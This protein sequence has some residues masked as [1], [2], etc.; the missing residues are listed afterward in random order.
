MKKFK[1]WSIVLLTGGMFNFSNLANVSPEVNAQDLVA[2][3]TPHTSAS[4]PKKELSGSKQKSASTYELMVLDIMEEN[5]YNLADIEFDARIKTYFMIPTDAGLKESITMT[6]ITYNA[7]L[8]SAWD[9][10]AVNIAGMSKEMVPV[11]G[12]GYT[13]ELL[14]PAN[15]SLALLS[16]K[17][18]KITYDAFHEDDYK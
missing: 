10:M 13:I 16:V 6:A 3:A 12:K 14:N 1:L 17:D 11:L 2:T 15:E 5:F 18:G 4:R 9:E 8:L 7:Q